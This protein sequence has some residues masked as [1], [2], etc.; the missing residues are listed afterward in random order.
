M[1]PHATTGISPYYLLFGLQPHLPIDALLGGREISEAKDWLFIHQERLRYAHEK[2]REF[3]EEKAL[4]RV[5]CLNERAFYPQVSVG[6][7]LYLH[8]QQIQDAW[9]P[10]NQMPSIGTALFEKALQGAINTEFIT[11]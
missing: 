9:S 8:H 10:C 1:T 7:F 11:D 5:T 4:E 6:E 3:L 2:A